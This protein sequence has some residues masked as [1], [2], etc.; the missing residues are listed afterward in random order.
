MSTGVGYTLCTVRH[1]LIDARC[2]I[3]N[4]L[5]LYLVGVVAKYRYYHSKRPK[6]PDIVVEDCHRATRLPAWRIPRH[7]VEKRCRF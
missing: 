3:L 6:K 5:F 7:I 1:L 2:G 4:V